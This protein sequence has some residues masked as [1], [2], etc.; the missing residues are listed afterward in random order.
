MLPYS[1]YPGS[2]ERHLKQR[3]DNPLFD[4]TQIKEI[5]IERLIEAQAD[6]HAD[7]LAFH[8]DFKAL[9]EE[10]L[11][12]KPNEESDLILKI[13]ERLDK[14]YE[15][16]SRVADDPSD[17][18]QAIQKL[19]NVIMNA[20][21]KGAETDPKALQELAQ[22]ETA[23]EAHFTLLESTLVADLLDPESPIQEQELIPTLLNAEIV[24]LQA[25]LQLFDQSQFALILINA[26]NLLNTLKKQGHHLQRAEQRWE[27]ML[28]YQNM[29]SQWQEA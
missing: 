28:A 24:D 2:H 27:V 29:L 19:L 23:R 18:K 3:L 6:D 14:N 4:D 10:T 17:E 8:R 11:A 1:E 26:E 20:I 16:A 9:L 5:K 15:H 21:R 22:E 25:A 12:L 13:K 7:L